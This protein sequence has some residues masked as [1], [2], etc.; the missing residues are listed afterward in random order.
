MKVILTQGTL[1]SMECFIIMIKDLM[2]AL[3]IYK[4]VDDSTVYEIINTSPHNK[5]AFRIQ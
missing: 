1:L 5:V 2:S 3:P 4:Y